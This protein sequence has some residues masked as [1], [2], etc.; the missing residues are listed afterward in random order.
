M[1]SL[2]GKKVLITGGSQGIG[3]AI[4]AAFLR[5]GAAVRIIARDATALADA[6]RE[7]SPLGTIQVS[8]CDVSVE[9][10]VEQTARTIRDTWHRLD[11]LVNAAAVLEPIGPLHEVTP[12][13]WLRTVAVDLYG[14]F[15]MMHY[16]VPLLRASA[17][18]SVINFVGGGEGAR[19]NFSAY[20][21][22]KGG[23]ARLTET[24]A[25][26]LREYGIAVNAIAPGA[27]N[28]KLLEDVLVA[29]PEKAG[30][31]E[32]DLA[33]KRKADGGTSPSK[34]ANL[35]TWL[36]TDAATGLTGRVLSAVWDDY[37]Q[38]RE[39][40]KNISTSDVFTMRRVRPSDRGFDWG[41]K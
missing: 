37:E 35:A 31:A 6:S 10:E 33:L 39:H 26:E 13:A 17:R 9:A 16:C 1:T 38:F 36:C 12:S 7:L 24:A 28:T 18:S 11:V 14:T 30:Q 32:Y 5:E 8:A 23:V 15:L 2:H 22:A 27:V 29:G 21:A 20:V 4:A 41:A 40:M 19:P 25:E 34:A 3:K